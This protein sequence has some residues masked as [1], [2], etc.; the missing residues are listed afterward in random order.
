MRPNGL[1]PAA[2]EDVVAQT[3][4]LRTAGTDAL[5][6]AARASGVRRLV[7]QSYAMEYAREGG[8]VGAHGERPAAGAAQASAAAAEGRGAAARTSISP[9]LSG[10]RQSASPRL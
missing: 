5:L 9:K 4:R 8:P 6:A 1:I 3:N 10:W 7:A 2:T